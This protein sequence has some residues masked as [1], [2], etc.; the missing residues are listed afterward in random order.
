MHHLIDPRTS[1][2]GGDGLSAVTVVGS[3]P[4]IAEVWSKALFLE[5]AAG[6][7]S[8]AGTR[9]IAAL[10]VYEDGSLDT[11]RLMEDYLIWRAP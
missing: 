5:G 11:S 4:A 1:R 6:I 3:D 7:V 10:W 8:A 9:G 2:P